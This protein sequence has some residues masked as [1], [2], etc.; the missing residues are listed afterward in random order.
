MKKTLLKLTMMVAFMAA[1]AVGQAQNNVPITLVPGWNWISYPNAEAMDIATAL[2]DFTPMQG[3]VIKAQGTT[4]SYRNGVWRGRLSQFLPGMGYK[5]YSMRSENVE[6]VFAQAASSFVTTAEPT[7]ITGTSAVV[8]G[9]V[10]LGEG[11]HVFA[12]GVCWSMEP[13]PD[14]DDSHS[15]DATV[16]GFLSVTLT[17]L[18]PETTYYVRAYVVTDYG[19]AYGEELSFTTLESGNSNVPTGAIDGKFSINED[20]GQVYFSQGNL[21]YQASSNTWKFAENQYDYVGSTN[22]NISSTYSGWIDLFGWGTSGY[23]HGAN[24]YQPWSTSQTAAIN[25]VDTGGWK[26]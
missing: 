14:V 2:G 6:L 25:K 17:G 23:N 20:G 9:T 1:M 16:T 24:C 11:N 21:Q 18:T 4:A 26:K 13:N 3:D 19:L 15:I 22:S 7:D 8:G 12:R 5:Y 10:T